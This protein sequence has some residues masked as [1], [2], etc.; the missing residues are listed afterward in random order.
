MYRP[1]IALVFLVLPLGACGSTKAPE[2]EPDAAVGPAACT[3]NTACQLDSTPGLCN[4]G[5]LCGLCEGAQDDAKC[6]AAYGAGNICVQ[7]ACVPGQCHTATDCG[8]GKQCVGNQCTGCSSDNDCDDGQICSAGTCTAAGAVCSGKTVGASCGTGELCCTRQG[9]LSCVDVQCC[10]NAQC[11]ANETCQSGQCV[12]TNSG[13]TA[14]PTPAY[15]V[16]PAY[17]GPSTGSQTCPF[18]TLHGALNAVRTDDFVGDSDVVIK[19]GTI[20]ATS[21]GGADRFPLTLPSSV[22]LRT[23]AGQPDATIIAPANTT[24]FDAPFVAQAAAQ[25]P[26]SAR[27]SH[28]TIKQAA[29]GTGGAAVIVTGGTVA[30]PVHIDHVTVSNFFNGINVDGGKALLAFGVDISASADAGLRVAAG[31]ATITVGANA[32]AFTQFHKNKVGILVTGDPASVLDATGSQDANGLDRISANDNTEA[33]IRIFSPNAGNSLLTVGA[34]RNGNN[35]LS[36]FGGAKI[37]V[38]HTRFKQN[39]ASG[40][41]IS[42]NGTVTDMSG[43]DLGTGADQGLIEFGGNPDTDLCIA[44]Q[45]SHVVSALGNLWGALDCSKAAG[46]VVPLHTTCAGAGAGV[47]APGGNAFIPAVVSTCTL[48]LQ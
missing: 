28:L 20:D 47:G 42:A 18:K 4:T 32:D 40:V 27:V 35:G 44:A 9:A 19:G 24:A 38:R 6:A 31:R 29:P 7:G 21:E 3:V 36:L 17:T 45:D 41:R 25:Q 34:N 30:K 26:W 15:F 11:G 22:F 8:S 5:G 46:G 14:P 2:Q 12:A 37:K 16:D 23:Q 13:C 48:K 10:T 33:G 43:I 39:G 1:L